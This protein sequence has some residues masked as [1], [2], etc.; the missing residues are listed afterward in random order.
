LKP[1]HL[2][3]IDQ[4]DEILTSSISYGFNQQYQGIFS[5]FDEEYSMIFD[6]SSPETLTSVDIRQHR[7]DRERNDFQIEHYLADQ[8]DFADQSAILTY[9]L[10]IDDELTDENRDD[11]KNLKFKEFLIDD[12]V[13]IYLGLI[14]LIFAFAYDQRINQCVIRNFSWY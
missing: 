14:D 11:L 10:A 9:S 8:D 7:L 5:K 2:L 1:V 3:T 13:S 6:N 4:P 12:P